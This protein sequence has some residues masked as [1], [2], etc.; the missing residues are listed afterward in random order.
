MSHVRICD[1]SE[2]ILNIGESQMLEHKQR[3]RGEIR[4]EN[5]TLCFLRVAPSGDFV[6]VGFIAHFSSLFPSF[7]SLSAAMGLGQSL[8]GPEWQT[9]AEC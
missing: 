9:L 1:E 7:G 2:M 8:P 6:C 4:K 5:T 3:K